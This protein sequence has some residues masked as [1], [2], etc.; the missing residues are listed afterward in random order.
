MTAPQHFFASFVNFLEGF[1]HHLRLF[2][3]EVVEGLELFVECVLPLRLAEV[4]VEHRCAG[5]V[6]EKLRLI[7][8][9]SLELRK[10][11]L[12]VLLL[13]QVELVFFEGCFDPLALQALS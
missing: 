5:Q 4:V 7:H 1:P 8:V 12:L 9:Q 2:R 6:F 11:R 13:A 3:P 10:E